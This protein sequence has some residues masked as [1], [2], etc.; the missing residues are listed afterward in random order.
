MD[1]NGAT[2][3]TSTTTTSVPSNVRDK[4]S[5]KI[6][7]KAQLNDDIR[8][9]MIH[10]EE[11]TLDEL[12]LMM[13]RVFVGKI[14]STDQLIIKYLDDDGD[15]I[16]L[17]TDSDLTVA[18][19]FHQILRLYLYI[20][21]YETTAKETSIDVKT[22]RHEL[23]QIQS[24]V[25]T[26]LDRL[27]A[28]P[29]LLSR[30]TIENEKSYNTAVAESHEIPLQQ[31]AHIQ[32]EFDPNKQQQ[33]QQ[34]SGTPDNM[35]SKPLLSNTGAN[36]EVQKGFE[37]GKIYLEF[38]VEAIKSKGFFSIHLKKCYT[39]QTESATESNKPL[40]PPPLSS[41]L[42]NQTNPLYTQMP[43]LP[44]LA[45]FSTSVPQYPPDHQMMPDSSQQY[46]GQS[47]TSQQQSQE[48]SSAL[49]ASIV[50]PYYHQ[51]AVNQQQQ[52]PSHYNISQH[53]ST[54]NDQG[55]HATQTAQQASSG[56][57]NYPSNYL[58][59]QAASSI[60]PATIQPSSYMP[61]Q[62]PGT[63]GMAP[64]SPGM[65]NAANQP[66]NPFAGGMQ[67]GQ[68]IQYPKVPQQPPR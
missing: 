6:I 44:P 59:A 29:A 8:K 17:L 4:L 34:R 32:E 46:I 19:H 56:S 42:Y 33:H 36:N 12:S 13:E 24:S 11:L 28:Q 67:Y 57:S 18:L 7:I 55:F 38:I 5:N 31:T 51:Q 10:N 50:H 68:S 16:T 48:P 15:K 37:L 61:P 9:I 58:A 41:N 21:G 43:S 20:D 1:I 66:P 60:P 52:W 53:P 26:I 65:F 45:K 62:V 23:Q 39:Q 25:Q 22:F 40:R 14:N 27:Q 35:I 64:P 30:K 49:S 54:S 2:T 3:P 47:Q 63:I